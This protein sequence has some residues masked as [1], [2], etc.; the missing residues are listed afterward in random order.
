MIAV[1]QGNEA[2]EAMFSIVGA[3][4][5]AAVMAGT[6][7]VHLVRTGDPRG[8]GG[9]AISLAGSGITPLVWNLPNLEVAAG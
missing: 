8:R 4:L 9:A 1:L 6:L 5:V 3:G 2:E 7:Y